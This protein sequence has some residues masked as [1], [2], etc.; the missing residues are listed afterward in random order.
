[1]DVRLIPTFVNPVILEDVTHGYEHFGH[2]IQREKFCVEF[3][4]FG[5][6]GTQTMLVSSIKLGGLHA[7]N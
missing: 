1:M 4:H 7:I 5:F 6:P 3:L 2:V